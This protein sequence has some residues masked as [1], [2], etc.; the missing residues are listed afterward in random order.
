MPFRSEK[1]R[2]YM[3]ANLPEI[4]KRWE[5]DYAS[6]GIARIP[7]QTGGIPFTPYTLNQFGNFHRNLFNAEGNWIKNNP[8]AYLNMNAIPINTQNQIYNK[9]IDA[10]DAQNRM[11]ALG[12]EMAPFKRHVHP[13]FT[14][15]NTRASGENIYGMDEMFAYP[16]MQQNNMISNM[17]RM[18]PLALAVMTGKHQPGISPHRGGY[19]PIDPYGNI[20]MML[21]KD[22]IRSG[23]NVQQ[24]PLSLIHI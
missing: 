18:K 8:S 3:H 24:Q 21:E 11:Y 6:G 5:R 2:R 19:G 17:E 1:Q 10:F 22:D 4:A 14:G 7:L 15:E 12:E 16:G 20:Q 13:S 9:E 23:A